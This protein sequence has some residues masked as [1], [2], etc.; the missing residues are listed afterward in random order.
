ML[1]ENRISK[2]KQLLNKKTESQSMPTRPFFWK[3]AKL[4]QRI[5]AVKNTQNWLTTKGSLTTQ[6]RQLC[7]ELE[8]VILSEKLERP[9]ANE[10]Q[11]L[12][13]QPSEPAWIRCVLLQGGAENWVY[14]RTV[15]P[16][17]LES[18]PWFHLQQLGNKPL[19]EV[20]FQDSAIQRTPFTFARHPLTNW[21]YLPL[22]SDQESKVV[23]YARRSVFTQQQAPLLLTEVFLPSLLKEGYS[24][25]T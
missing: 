21:P 14:A 18:N 16:H 5:S 4:I 24:C 10:A 1:A 13:L 22:S 17:F 11:S 9:L 6:L 25:R 3:P 7:P 12:G 23:G 19:G 15:I 2:I 8:V 20:L